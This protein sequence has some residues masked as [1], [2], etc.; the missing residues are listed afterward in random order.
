MSMTIEIRPMTQCNIDLIYMGLSGYDIS[1]PIGIGV[2]LNANYGT[3]QKLYI[4]RGFIPDGRGI[5]YN[6]MPVE[7]G[8][9]VRVDDDLILYLTKTKLK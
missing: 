3:A 9:Q 8:F 6:N 4:K 5:I 2:G 1:K 7:A